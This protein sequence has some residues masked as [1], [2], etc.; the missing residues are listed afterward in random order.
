[1]KKL[2]VKSRG[3]NIAKNYFKKECVFTTDFEYDTE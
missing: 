2:Y 3:A 1:M